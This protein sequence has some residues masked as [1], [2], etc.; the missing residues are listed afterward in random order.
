MALIMEPQCKRMTLGSGGFQACPNF[1]HVVLFEDAGELNKALG[2]VSKAKTHLVA[3]ASQ[4]GLHACFGDVE[5]KH[6]HCGSELI[7][8]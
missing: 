8:G 6:R 4:L 5:T 3:R 7:S 1:W 2:V